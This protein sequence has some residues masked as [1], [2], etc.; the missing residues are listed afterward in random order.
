MKATCLR[1]LLILSAL[2]LHSPV[3]MAQS[4]AIPSV[5]DNLLN[6]DPENPGGVPLMESLEKELSG[7][8]KSTPNTS[9][10]GPGTSELLEKFRQPTRL[11]PERTARPEPGPTPGTNIPAFIN[12]SKPVSQPE[13][14]EDGRRVVGEQQKRDG[15]YRYVGI[16]SAKGLEGKAWG[17][18]TLI[19]PRHIITAG[20][21]CVELG[22]L[23]KQGLGETVFLLPDGRSSSIERMEVDAGWKNPAFDIA[24]CTLTD[25][26]GAKGHANWDSFED[27]R[28]N[29]LIHLSGY[30]KDLA[31]K[32][33]KGFV[34]QLVDRQG[35]VEKCDQNM[36]KKGV[37]LAIISGAVMFYSML[38]KR[39]SNTSGG[40]LY[41]GA[42]LF[43]GYNILKSAVFDTYGWQAPIFAEVGASGGP[44]W[45]E[46]GSHSVVLGVQSAITMLGSEIRR[47]GLGKE[48]EPAGVVGSR[49]TA[50]SCKKMIENHIGGHPNGSSDEDDFRLVFMAYP[51]G[52]K[53]QNG[54]TSLPGHAFVGF[55]RNGSY[56]QIKG[57]EADDGNLWKPDFSSE[58]SD[59]K[60]YL[61]MA[62]I[63]FEWKV[64]KSIYDKAIKTKMAGYVG[65]LND[66]V[67]YAATIADIANLNRP[68][69]TD[70]IFLPMD[71]VQALKTMNPY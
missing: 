3:L 54:D 53:H 48:W 32:D 66:C 70:G 28:F 13:V 2:M 15:I 33:S 9:P 62:T 59:N 43:G 38:D 57:F 27:K 42:A 58:L 67:T 6:L 24:V 12:V 5:L 16:L 55:V 63:Q 22:K 10:Q 56:E 64:S 39:T 45:I 61:P 36:K 44:I 7:L 31:A 23:K 35:V 50:G 34:P 18:A 69:P 60:K 37:P 29:A 40:L 46:N 11:L 65:I 25:S 47:S 20:H 30:D 1:L 52:S 14:R 41:G 4:A 71:Y 26:L 17:T 19:G 49:I 68:K 21:V 8:L 51:P